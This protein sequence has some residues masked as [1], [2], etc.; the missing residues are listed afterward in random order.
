[1]NIPET[2]IRRPVMT[3]LIMVAI[4]MFGIVAH[5]SLPIAELPNVDF[6]TI[7]VSARLPGGNPETMAA[8]VATPLENQFSRIAGVKAMTSV[9]SLGQTRVTLEFEL[10]RKIDEAAL[11]LWRE[12]WETQRE[13]FGRDPWEYGMTPGNVKNLEQ[14]VGYAHRQGLMPRKMALDELFLNPTAGAK[15]DGIFRF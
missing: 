1:M 12:E 15:R 14:M 13:I 9:S 5:R 11:A 7:E 3:T 6:P 2:C 8:S 4:V 10:S